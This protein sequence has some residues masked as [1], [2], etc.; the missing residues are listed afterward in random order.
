M[1]YLDDQLRGRVV[2]VSGD[3]TEL[4]LFWE[5]IDAVALSVDQSR[6][7]ILRL[8]DEYK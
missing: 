2:T 7:L 5:I 6:E 8:L 4:E 1:G 3:L